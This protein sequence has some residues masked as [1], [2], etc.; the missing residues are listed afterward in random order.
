MH[1]AKDTPASKSSQHGQVKSAAAAGIGFSVCAQVL[2]CQLCALR[3]HWP[4][5]MAVV[6]FEKGI[7]RRARVIAARNIQPAG[8]SAHSSA[9]DQ[10]SSEAGDLE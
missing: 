6:P 3:G 2:G 5:T 7:A 9:V 4:G 10:R 8:L 1:E